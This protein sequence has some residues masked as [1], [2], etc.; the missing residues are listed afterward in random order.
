[1]IPEMAAGA[2]ARDAKRLGQPLDL[3]SVIDTIPA[4]VVC[5]LPDGSVEFANQSWREYTGSSLEQLTGWGWLNVIHPHDL[6]K[7]MDEW[8]AARA[9]GK[10]FKNEARV[11]RVDGEYRWFLISKVPLRDLSEPGFTIGRG[12]VCEKSMVSVSRCIVRFR[13]QRR[14][15]RNYGC[16]SIR[17]TWDWS[18]ISLA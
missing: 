8:T 17:R 13:T 2:G 15:G 5:A 9:A 10:P 11:R 16:Y 14:R 3:R 1:M 7:F 12:S 4:L 18:A 6:P